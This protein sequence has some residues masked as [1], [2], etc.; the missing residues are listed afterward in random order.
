M[1]KVTHLTADEHG[2]LN[3]RRIHLREISGDADA[4]L[5]TVG[6]DLR[7]ARMRRGDDL[8]TVSR[9][10]KIRKDHLEAIE[11]DR[12]E[13]LPGRTYAVGF[14]RS[15]A[16]YLG[17]DP[18]TA[19]ERFKGEIAGR[20]DG[21]YQIA[22]APEADERPL[23]HG[24][25]VIAIVLLVVVAFGAYRLAKSADTLL[26]EPVG[27]VPARITPQPTIASLSR[28][29]QS[30][31]I[32][33]ANPVNPMPS[34]TKPAALPAKG[35][36]GLSQ[37]AIGGG[38]SPANTG[39]S[40]PNSGSAASSPLGVSRTV[41]A[42]QPGNS[43]TP[44]IPV[45]EEYGRQNKDARVILR[46]RATTRV[47]VQGAD[48]TVFINRVLKPGDTYRVPD[49]VG[50]TLTAPDGGAVGVELDGQQMGTAGS[51]GHVTEALS[52]DPQ[53][54]VDR[55]SGRGPG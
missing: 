40:G 13:A 47:V 42:T 3:R 10:L 7:T 6:Q 35:P 48:G 26:K 52:L 51:Q 34:A 16:D 45:G 29:S 44:Q 11:E 8:A 1:T 14:V 20:S 54:I 50:L 5:E 30:S 23:P 38:A 21:S 43:P 36:T 4:P 17:L 32:Q 19:V 53:A 55:Y 31:G 27:A 25:V 37:Q 2:G 39:N 9:A 12:L 46:A 24:W 18:A 15:Y 28:H 33:A 41:A 49:K 22:L